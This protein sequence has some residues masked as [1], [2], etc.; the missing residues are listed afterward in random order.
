MSSKTPHGAYCAIMPQAF[1]RFTTNEIISRIHN[2]SL[3]TGFI[4]SVFAVPSKVTNSVCPLPPPRLSKMCVRAHTH[5]HSGMK[6]K[7]LGK[8]NKP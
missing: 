2:F 3:S 8:K 5:T 6:R 1:S 4:Q 7:L